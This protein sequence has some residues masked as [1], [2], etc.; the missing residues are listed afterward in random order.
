LSDQD[1]TFGDKLSA[2]CSLEM[3]RARRGEADFA[4]M[5]ERLAATLGLTIALAARG[6]GAVIDRLLSG[7]EGYAH[8]EAVAKA[9][10]ARMVA[11]ANGR[12]G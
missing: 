2:L 8:S 10:F 11:A 12:S 6:D 4:D 3:A 7:A 5:I 1:F 9:P